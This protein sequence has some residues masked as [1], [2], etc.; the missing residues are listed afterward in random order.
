ME[1]DMPVLAIYRS[2]DV[3]KEAFCRY[4]VENPIEPAPEGAIFHQVAFDDDGL[5]VIDVWDSAAQLQAYGKA[6]IVPALLKLGIPPVEPQVLE[7]YGLW[8]APDAARRN[9]DVPAP[10]AQAVPA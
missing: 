6:A 8:A 5:L 4:R 2:K 9:V 10:Q 3:S 7:V 1:A